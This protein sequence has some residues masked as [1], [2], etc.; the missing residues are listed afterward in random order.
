MINQI[1][2]EPSFFAFPI[3]NPTI[4]RYYIP[5]ISITAYKS[6]IIGGNYTGKSNGNAQRRA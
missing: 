1:I 3:D 2:T 6:Y 5:V 4:L